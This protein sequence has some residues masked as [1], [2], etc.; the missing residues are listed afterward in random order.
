MSH[1]FCTNLSIVH[2]YID[3]GGKQFINLIDCWLHEVVGQF[4]IDLKRCLLP[5][6]I[7]LLYQCKESVWTKRRK[8]SRYICPYTMFLGMILSHG[9]TTLFMISSVLFNWLLVRDG[10]FANTGFMPVSSKKL[11]IFCKRVKTLA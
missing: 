1:V 4:F 5:S 8:K 2:N 3:P 10:E 11:F 6:A 9:L 7:Q